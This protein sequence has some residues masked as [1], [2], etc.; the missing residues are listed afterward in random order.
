LIRNQKDA[1]D[2]HPDYVLMNCQYVDAET[3]DWI[4]SSTVRIVV[5]IFIEEVSIRR[6]DAV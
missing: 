1:V 2:L 4:S 5:G 3:Q 6:C